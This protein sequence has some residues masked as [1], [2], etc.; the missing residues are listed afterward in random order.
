MAPA[1]ARPPANQFASHA[2]GLD[3]EKKIVSEVTKMTDA[4]A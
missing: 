2:T 1:V 3:I 4:E